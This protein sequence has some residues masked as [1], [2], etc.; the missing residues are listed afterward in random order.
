MVFIVKKP[1]LCQEQFLRSVE[2]AVVFGMAANEEPDDGIAANNAA[3]RT[4]AA[5]HPDRV[6]VWIGLN[7]LEVET[8]MS[9][10]RLKR[11]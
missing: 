7:L 2:Q 8:A 6:P 3:N 5:A 9:G 10:V 4:I 1:T 11:W